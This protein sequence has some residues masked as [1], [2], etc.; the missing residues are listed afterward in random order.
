VPTVAEQEREQLADLLVELGPDEPTLCEGWATRDLA[1]HLVLRERRPLAALGIAITPL[2]GYT[3]HVQAD[4]ARTP[5][6]EL[7]ETLRH[8]S[9]LLL[10]PTD[11]IVNTTQASNKW[12]QFQSNSLKLHVTEVEIDLLGILPNAGDTAKKRE[13]LEK[14]EEKYKG[15]KAK[16]QDEALEFTAEAKKGSD[17]NDRCDLAGLFLQISIVIASVA[18]LSRQRFL[19][20]A[21]LALAGFGA[22]KFF[23]L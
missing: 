13:D 17:M 14:K 6:L 19:W 11:S 22:V 16:A 9:P 3:R 21:G 10:G 23:F 20:Y 15:E 4:V 5:W 8:P 2:A 18:I 1:A 12:Q 7:V